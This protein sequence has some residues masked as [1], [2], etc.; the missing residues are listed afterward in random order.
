MLI[1]IYINIFNNFRLLTCV[2]TTELELCL[3]KNITYI[4]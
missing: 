3:K 4:I 2:H 1:L